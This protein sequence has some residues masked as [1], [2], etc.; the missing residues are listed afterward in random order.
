MRPLFLRLKELLGSGSSM[1]KYLNRLMP[2]ANATALV[3]AIAHVSTLAFAS[4]G[5]GLEAVYIAVLTYM[6]G[7]IAALIVGAALLAIVGFFKLGLLSSLALFFIVI[8]SVAILIVVYLF[9]SDFTQVP[10]QYGF[11]SLPPTLTAWYCSVYFVWKKGNVIE[12][13]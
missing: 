9:E 4:R 3:A 10:L 7:F 12:G 13:R 1:R 8:H 5:I 2:A 11:I 6:I